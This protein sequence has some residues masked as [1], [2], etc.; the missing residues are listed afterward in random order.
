MSAFPVHFL[1]GMQPFIVGGIWHVCVNGMFVQVNI[2]VHAQQ[3]PFNAPTIVTNHTGWTS[4]KMQSF[5]PSIY[6]DAGNLV[7][8]DW[9]AGTSVEYAPRPG[10]GC[11]IRNGLISGWVPQNASFAQ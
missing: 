11:Y 5:T 9:P 6:N 10:G 3:Q 1:Q 7:R 2:P 8:V 4:V